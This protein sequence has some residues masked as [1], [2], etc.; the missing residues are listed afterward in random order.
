[1]YNLNQQELLKKLEAKVE[2]M[3]D[4]IGDKSPH[5]ARTD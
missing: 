4:Q 1:M 2:R 3:V 5:V